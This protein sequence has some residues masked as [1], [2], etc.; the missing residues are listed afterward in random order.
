MV[1]LVSIIDE[2]I[3]LDIEQGGDWTVIS[4]GEDDEEKGG[5]VRFISLVDV[6]NSYSGMKGQTPVVNEDET[7]LEFKAVVASK[8]TSLSDCPASYKNQK[9][10]IVQVKADES[11]LQ[12]INVNTD[13][14]VFPF[15][16]LSDVQGEY[17]G[18]GGCALTIT[19]GENGIEYTPRSEL[20]PD[21]IVA[22]TAINPTVTVNSKGLVTNIVS[23]PTKENP[24]FPELSVL[25]GDGTNVPTYTNKGSPFQVPE[26]NE[27]G[28]KIVMKYKNTLHTDSGQLG[29]K[30]TGGSNSYLNI[31]T[32]A[33]K[34][35]IESLSKDDNPTEL[36]VQTNGGQ[37]TLGGEKTSNILVKNNMDVTSSMMY[38]SEGINFKP[39]GSSTLRIDISGLSLSNY[40]TLVVNDNDIPNK[41]YVDEAILN[42]IYAGAESISVTA[43]VTINHTQTEVILGTIP[44]NKIIDELRVAITSPYIGEAKI[45]VGTDTKNNLIL[46]SVSVDKEG[47]IV[48]P[49]FLQTT[50]ATELKLFTT[51]SPTSGTL[52]AY[53]KYV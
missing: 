21:I 41:K 30:V 12:F 45:S 40:H 6:P 16:N 36:S 33:N 51:G 22:Q 52:T 15:K 25:Y 17:E 9:N 20:L 4:Y 53:V 42:A 2:P 5:G 44:A 32:T 26:V 38:S 43:P 46:N 7:G 3:R 48:I 23:N 1:D 24:D 11:G 28:D 34:V 10:K 27:S 29:A 47:L 14:N 37:L 39:G 8:F 18:F 35:D 19:E 50:E 49:F 13:I 31:N